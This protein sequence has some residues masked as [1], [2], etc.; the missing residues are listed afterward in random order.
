MPDHAVPEDYRMEQDSLGPVRVPAWAYWGAQT[1]RA[2]ENF[3]ISGLRLPRRFIRAQGI[4][5]WAA[6]RANRAVGALDPGRAE[7][8]MTAAEEVIDGRW[9]AHF[10]VDV[11]QAGAGTSQ[12][13]NANEV[14]A[15]RAR[16][17]LGAVEDVRRVHPNDHVNL[18][19][20][21]NDT[22]HVAIHIAGAEAVVQD[23]LPAL[24]RMEAVLRAKAQGWMGIIKTGRTHLQDAVP[25]RLGQE[26]GLG[27]G[28]GRL[29]AGPGRAG[30]GA[31]PHRLRG[32]RSRDRYQR[33][34]RLPPPGGGGGGGADGAA[35]PAARQH[36]HLHPEPGRRAGGLR[37]PAGAG[38]RPG[39]DRQR[40]APAELGPAGG[41]GGA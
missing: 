28:A 11:Y 31:V 12:N 33:P 10:V 18:A 17:I 20:S 22:I 8:I 7:A 26:V 34:S 14:I 38:H 3:P 1:Q 13:M 37:P 2:V 5:K 40:C 24:E 39:Q 16:E 30:G 41:A 27:G 25:L 23:L 21:T 9:D 35:L 4:I 15:R 36:V 19:Q 29:A 32:Q 6:A